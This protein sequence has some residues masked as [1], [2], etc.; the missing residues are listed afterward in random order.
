MPA[1]WIRATLFLK[2][3]LTFACSSGD[4]IPVNWKLGEIHIIHL[5]HPIYV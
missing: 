1:G 3:M 2:E 4:E 5:N